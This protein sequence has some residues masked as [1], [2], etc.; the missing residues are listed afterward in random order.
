M[1]SWERPLGNTSRPQPA[2]AFMD[3]SDDGDNPPGSPYWVVAEDPM[4][5]NGAQ[6]VPAVSCVGAPIVY[7]VGVAPPT[8]VVVVAAA[9]VI[10]V[11]VAVAAAAS[12]AVAVAVVVG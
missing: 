10:A 6:V 2:R 9:A 4:P 12:V 11:V 5:L 1:S 7:V 3:R 8:Q